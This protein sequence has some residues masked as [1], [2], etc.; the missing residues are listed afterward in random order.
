MIPS[1]QYLV[2]IPAQGLLS[3]LIDT[4]KSPCIRAQEIGI[5]SVDAR[6]ACILRRA[7][8]STYT[9]EQAV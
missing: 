2:A 3:T 5:S 7:T 6:G 8:A 4:H 9:I 1:L